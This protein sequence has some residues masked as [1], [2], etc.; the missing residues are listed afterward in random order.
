MSLPHHDDDDDS[1]ASPVSAISPVNTITQDTVSR[2]RLHSSPERYRTDSGGFG[3]GTLN[4]VPEDGAVEFEHAHVLPET[5]DDEEDEWDI[6]KK[7]EEQGFYRGSYRTLVL[8]YSFVPLTFLIGFIVFALLPILLNPSDDAQQLYP[9]NDLLPFPIPELLVSISLNSF[10]HVLRSPFYSLSQALFS[11]FYSLFS[12]SWQILHPTLSSS[13]IIALSTVIHTLVSTGLRLAVFPILLVSVSVSPE[14]S[15]FIV[16]ND[17]SQLPSYTSFIRVWWIALGWALVEAVVGIVQGYKSI[18]LYKDVLVNIDEDGNLVRKHPDVEDG[19]EREGE[20]GDASDGGRKGKGKLAK[21]YGTFQTQIQ[22][23]LP[24]QKI[25]TQVQQPQPFSRNDDSYPNPSSSPQ[26]STLS[27]EVSKQSQ[28]SLQNQPGGIGIGVADETGNE[29]EP[30]L[31][32]SVGSMSRFG[33]R[34]DIELPYLTNLSL[35]NADNCE[36]LEQSLESQVDEDLEEL[37]MIR[38]R[39]DLERVYGIPFIRIPVFVLCLQRVNSL[40]FS[41]GVTLLLGRAYLALGAGAVQPQSK[42]SAQFSWQ[43]TFPTYSSS[44]I[45]QL[46]AHFT[47][48]TLPIPPKH[49]MS[50]I[51]NRSQSLEPFTLL[52]SSSS[53]VTSSPSLPSPATILAPTTILLVLLSILQSQLLL[54]RLGVH[55][56]VYIGALISLGIFFAGLG[57]WGVL[58]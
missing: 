58:E 13:L 35:D 32:G 20:R 7:L 45:P 33:R 3:G 31:T 12:S 27:R 49:L 36:N 38:A 16:H 4:R 8:F 10:S 41:L 25:P 24:A 19:A 55:I 29:Q 54:P 53:S 9:Y 40:L 15:T 48:T 14:P 34:S 11:R 37:M 47:T 21:L 56:V 17:D 2:S 57:V 18:T 6:D 26:F 51:A 50:M 5:V 1:L 23:S 44:S 46:S 42:A 39:D 52:S 28:R 22:S 43:P 30:L